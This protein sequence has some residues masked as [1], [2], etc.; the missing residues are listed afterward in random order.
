VPTTAR[1]QASR[2]CILQAAEGSFA[3]HGY[4][5][6]SVSEIM[7]RSGLAHGSFYVYFS[8]KQAIFAEL[9]RNLAHEIREVTRAAS[10]SSTTRLDAELAGTKAFFGWLRDHR[11]L[12]RILHLIDEVDTSLAVEFYSSIAKGYS[13]GLAQAM[14]T[15]E[16]QR[17]D[18]EL[19]AYA[20]MGMNQFISMRWILWAEQEVA[21]SLLEDMARIV[22]GAVRGASPIERRAT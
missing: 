14:E 11:D 22:A 19:L 6:T 20:L 7:R 8:S 2:R 9:I 16:A 5:G 1:G 18:P 10:S 4:S 13:E 12:H 15:G 17:V 21:D 3:E